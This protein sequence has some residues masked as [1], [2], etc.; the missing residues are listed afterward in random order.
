LPPPIAARWTSSERPT[1]EIVLMRAYRSRR[2]LLIGGGALALA[3][4]GAGAQT[5]PPPPPAPASIG[6]AR[7]EADGTIVL[8]LIARDP[9]GARGEPEMRYP[10]AHPDYASILRHVGPLR[11]GEE[12][13]VAPW[14]D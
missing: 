1:E 6:T 13:P 11:P 9:G 3:A 8:R 14:S 2:R 7:M 5:P 12:R 4:G 10:T